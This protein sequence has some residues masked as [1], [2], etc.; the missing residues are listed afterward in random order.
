MYPFVIQKVPGTE[1]GVNYFDLSDWETGSGEEW[2]DQ[3]I[4]NGVFTSV[5]G[6]NPQCALLSISEVS[7][8]HIT[9]YQNPFVDTIKI[10]SETEIEAIQ[11]IDVFGKTIPLELQSDIT[12]TMSSLNAGVYF[13]RLKRDAVIQI[14]RLIKK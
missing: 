13:F 2:S 14:L 4:D 7:L 1:S 9:V 11:L 3:S 10:E 6:V 5:V 8:T 12:V